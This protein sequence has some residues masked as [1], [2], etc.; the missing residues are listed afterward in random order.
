LASTASAN[1]RSWPGR[2]AGAAFLDA[3][4]VSMSRGLAAL[5]LDV[6]AHISTGEQR[7]ALFTDTAGTT[8][9][10]NIVLTSAVGVKATLYAPWIWN[11]VPLTPFVSIGFDH[12]FS[13]SSSLNVPAQP[14]FTV[15]DAITLFD[16]VRTSG[17][18]EAGLEI[19]SLRNMSRMTSSFVRFGG[20][21]SETGGTMSLRVAFSPNLR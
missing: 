7:N 15:G 4:V 12:D 19:A 16:P 21:F 20:S 5:Q 13:Y 3:P 17:S 8:W 14:N 18:V 6:R 2:A 9:G 10:D 1:V 11:A